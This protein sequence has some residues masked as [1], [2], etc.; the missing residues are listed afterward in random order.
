MT[1]KTDWINFG[2]K[3]QTF[4][5]PPESD[6]GDVLAQIHPVLVT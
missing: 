5:T 4:T 3:D 6:V 2:P 1:K